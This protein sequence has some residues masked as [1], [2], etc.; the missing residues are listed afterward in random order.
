MFYKT[1]VLRMLLDV[2]KT[3]INERTVNMRY[4]IYTFT[5]R[6]KKNACFTQV[7]HFPVYPLHNDRII[8]KIINNT[9]PGGLLTSYSYQCDRFIIWF[10]SDVLR[11]H[12]GGFVKCVV[13][14][15]HYDKRTTVSQIKGQGHSRWLI[16]LNSSVGN[17]PV[18]TYANPSQI[19]RVA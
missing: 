10:V 5:M 7:A 16:C 13:T 17:R 19:D 18:I 2:R 6:F 15:T 1:P 3:C 12:V 4:S 9:Y 8:I 14:Y 11:I